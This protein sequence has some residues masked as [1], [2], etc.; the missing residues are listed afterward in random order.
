MRTPHRS[1][2]AAGGCFR[3]FMNTGVASWL[4]CPQQGSR[5]LLLVQD[6]H[7]VLS[8]DCFPP[9]LLWVVPTPAGYAIPS[10]RKVREMRG[11]A[12][13]LELCHPSLCCSE[14][15]RGDQDPMA[16]HVTSSSPPGP[17]LRPEKKDLQ[18]KKPLQRALKNASV[19]AGAFPLWRPRSTGIP[20]KIGSDPAVSL[21]F[22]LN[23]MALTAKGKPRGVCQ[24]RKVAVGIGK[25][26][27]TGRHGAHGRR[28]R[29]RGLPPAPLLRRRNVSRD[30][31][32]AIIIEKFSAETDSDAVRGENIKMHVHSLALQQMLA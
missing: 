12:S 13:G 19:A 30:L 3:D 23:F 8:P 17:S 22:V 21:K 26:R 15:P 16:A 14:R 6:G 24:H 29:K 4:L 32:L 2:E 1:V 27:V 28:G 11:L 25:D 31:L 10:D 18:I 5:L 20:E 9:L 7:H